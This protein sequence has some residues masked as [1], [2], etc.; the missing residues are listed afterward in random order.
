MA[1]DAERDRLRT[2]LWNEWLETPDGQRYEAGWGDDENRQRA[3]RG[4]AWVEER[5]RDQGRSGD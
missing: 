1:W 4:K 2:R 3:A 5:I